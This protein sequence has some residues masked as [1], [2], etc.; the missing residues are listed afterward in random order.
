M[1]KLIALDMDGTLLNPSKEISKANAEAIRKARAKGKK[2][3][4][5]TG[6]P[7]VGIKKYLD[8]LE[9]NGED[10]YVVAFNGALVQSIKTGEVLSQTTLTIADYV[11]LYDLSVTLDVNVQALTEDL[12]LTPKYNPYSEVE[13]KINHIGY[14]EGPVSEVPEETTIVKVMF[15]DD[16][17][18]LDAII[19]MLP[20]PIV[21]KYTIV[22][23]ADIFL[24]FLHKSV[25]KGTGVKAVAEALGLEA[26]Q[27]IAVGDAGND[28]DMIEY[29]GL[30]VAMENAY[31]EVKD[32]ADHVTLSNEKD[33][34]AAVIKKFM[35]D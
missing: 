24:E 2:V 25:N 1:Y 19:P 16:P 34:V 26:A 12:V 15:V 14:I 32:A 20:A 35:L 22:R 9:M 29:A 23:S 10:D 27:V 31:D 4:I 5:A 3:I 18:K 33:G 28:I 8:H 11:E 7:L 17:K 21:E 13:C 6:R 30:G